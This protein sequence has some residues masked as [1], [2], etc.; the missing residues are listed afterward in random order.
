[1][2]DRLR[3]LASERILVIDGAMGTMIQ[4]Y[5]LGEDDFRGTRF[6]DHALPLKG[7]ND[8]LSITQADI[9]EEIHVR[10]LEAGADIIETNSFNGTSIAMADYGLEDLSYEINREAARVARKAVDRYMKGDPSRPRFVAGSMGPTNRTGSISPDVTNPAFRAITFDQLREAYYQ[11]AK[12]LVEGGADILL[13]ET[14]FDTLNLKAALFGIQE[15]FEETGIVLPVIASVT[16]VDESGRNLSGQTP[17]AFWISVHHAPLLGVGINC[18]LGP[19]A[20]RPYV[21]ELATRSTTLVSCVPNAGLPNAFGGY[22]ETPEQ[23][24][25]TLQAFA[26]EGW[27]NFAG[28]CCG[29]TPEHIRAIAQAVAGQKPHARRPASA[30]TELS[31]LEPLRIRPESNFIVI[32]E[33]TNVTGS[34]RFARLVKDGELEQALEV[35]RHQVDGGAN[36]LD[37]NMDEGLLD[38]EKEMTTFLHLITSEPDIARLPIMVDSSKFSVIEAGLRCLQGKCIVNSISLKE[39]EETFVRQA[40]IVR[41]HGAAVV[42]MAFDEQGQATDA[43]RKVEICKRAYRILTEQV[44]FPPEDIVFDP[45][46]LTVATGMEEH[47]TYALSFLEA[48]KRIK[49]ECPGAKVSGGISNLSFSF[50]GNEH[51]REAMNSVFLY[52]AIRAGLDMGIVNAGQLAVYDEID[53]A[54]RVKIEDVLFNRSPDATEA[55]IVYAQDVQGPGKKQEKDEAWREGTVEQRL[56]HALVRGI[57]DHID[58]DTEEARQKL[59]RPISVIE[60]P[61]M[62]GMNIVGELFGSGKMFLPQVVKSARVMKKAVAYLEPFMEEEKQRTGDTTSKAKVVLATVK[63]DVHDIGKN[64][65]GV[66]LACNG[67]DIVDL[68]V[69]VPAEKIL[70]TAEKE[71]ADFVGLSGLITP[72][73][74]EMVHV[75]SELE[76]R[77]FHVPLLIGGATTS[78]KHT[79]VKIAPKYGR[80]TIH[81]VDASRAVTTVGE[82]LRDETREALTS[83]N[84]EEQEALRLDFESR[85]QRILPYAAVQRRALDME[86]RSEDIAKPDFV[87]VRTVDPVPLRDLVDYIDWTPFFH[88]WELKGI[89]PNLLDEPQAGPAARELL[90]N[91]HELLEQLISGGRL[92]AKAVYGFFP[93]NR[94][95]DD[96]IIYEDESRET[97]RERLY[98]LRQQQEKRGEQPHL[99]LSDFIAPVGHPDFVGAFTVTAGIGADA[100]SKEF[101]ADHDD[102]HSIMVKALTD[103]LAEALAEKIHETAREHCGF[104]Q[105]ENLE[106]HDLIREKYRGIRPAPGYPASP[107]HSEKLTLFR[108]LDAEKHTGVSLTESFAMVPTASVSGFYFNHPQAKYFSVGKIGRD[109]VEAYAARK[110]EPPEA[111]ERSIRSSLGY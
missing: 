69:M 5:E 62:D 2:I 109:Q 94:D 4:G 96:I 80:D 66:V 61:L 7:A 95:G 13:P 78:R 54:L 71:A 77:D 42:V 56:S 100:I 31:G 97:E 34:R 86:W 9:I 76:R 79:A 23:M 19:Q 20:M 83:R 99:S 92:E 57:V 60:G 48:T 6:R 41:R 14:A 90:D 15:L 98:M 52:H 50:R 55:L 44:G 8:L 16:I 64:I 37:V 35:A 17:E 107:D 72:S 11:Q 39:G 68:G 110:G 67:Y 40:R 33:R 3:Q 36:I 29:S 58:E 28:G 21:E 74:D 85:D 82:F 24:A 104:G 102:Y 75:A 32:G 27:L 84:R 65:V 88:V 10:Y 18:A 105:E 53:E 12:G 63:G 106:K 49:A 73:L 38:S 30:F 91:A 51:V 45:N 101:E 22:D 25:A 111:I 89:Y 93:A 81:I 43:S 108:L 1:M 46:V 47:N 59:E 87:G 103:R 70:D 26:A